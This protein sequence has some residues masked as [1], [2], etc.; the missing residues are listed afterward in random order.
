MGSWPE[1]S[2]FIHNQF[3]SFKALVKGKVIKALEISRGREEDNLVFTL[4][5][6]NGKQSR[7][8]LSST[9]IGNELTF[10][11]LKEKR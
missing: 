2:G 10:D 1:K 4:L 3:D 11:L 9:S 6:E 7:V 8:R 5:D